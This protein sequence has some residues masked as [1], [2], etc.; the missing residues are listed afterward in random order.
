MRRSI[1]K[2]RAATWSCI[3][4]EHYGDGAPGAR[5]RVM[6]RSVEEFHREIS[7]RNYRYTRPGLEKTPW[8]TLETGAIDPFGN[9]I[10]FCELIDER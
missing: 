1:A 7:V 10:R 4:S 6:M 5:L 9:L 8:D 2:C 3:L